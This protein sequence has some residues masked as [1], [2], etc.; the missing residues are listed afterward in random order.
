MTC[1]RPDLC[2]AVNIL[3]KYQ[4]KNNNEVCSCIKRV[5]RCIKGT[6]NHKLTYVK[7]Q[8]SDMLFGYAASF[9][10]CKRSYLGPIYI[11]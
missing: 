5:F 8:Y 2:I 10:S 4:F 3:S 11:K 6:I 1:T 7:G 9:T